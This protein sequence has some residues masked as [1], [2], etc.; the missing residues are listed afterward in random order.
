MVA[1]VCQGASH[2]ILALLSKQRAWAEFGVVPNMSDDEREHTG[3]LQNLVGGWKKR[4][5]C[6][7]ATHPV[8]CTSTLVVLVSLCLAVVIVGAVFQGRIDQ[9]VQEVIGKVG[10]KKA[11]P[12]ATSLCP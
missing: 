9:E 2:P 5:R 1:R 4:R 11:E 3:E 6:C 10:V 8:C 12:K 7:C